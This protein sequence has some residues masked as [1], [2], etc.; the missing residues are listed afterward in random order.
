MPRP[1][2]QIDIV[3]G[4]PPGGAILDSG[5]AFFVGVSER[6]PVGEYVRVSSLRNYEAN[7]GSR[8][9]GSLLY[10]SAG[11]FFAEGGA[12]L[13]VSRVSGPSATRAQIPFGDAAAIA[14]SPGA[15]GNDID[16]AA[17]D[18]GSLSTTGSTAVEV[19]Y[20]G[21]VVERSPGLATVDDLVL[22]AQE[23]SDYVRFTKGAGNALPTVGTTVSLAGGTTDNSITSTGVADAL[24]AFTYELGPGQVAAPGLTTVATHAAVLEHCYGTRRNALLDL[25]DSSDPTVLTAAITALAGYAPWTRFA[26]ALAPWAVYPAST[27]P[28]TVVIPYSGIQAGLIARS[29]AATNNPN[30]PAAGA[31]GISRMALGLTQTYSDD[32]RQALNE[33]GIIIAIVKYG[34]VRTYGYRTASGPNDTNW[35]WYGGSR[36]VNALAHEA[37]AIAENYVL[38]QIDGQ[39][40]LFASLHNALKGLCLEHYTRGALYG[41]TPDEAFRVDTGPTINT[42]QTTAAGEIHA[43]IRVRTSPAAEW[44]QISIVKVPIE[45]S[46]AVAA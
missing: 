17:V 25:P 7:F 8:M 27:P 36:E 12:V 1:G 16:V 22:W 18:A 44:V 26:A 41:A 39:G 5:Q 10:D 13:L 30:V 40:A 21:T 2:T 43:V 38:R 11:A 29:D 4:A 28:A 32:V 20:D 6:G 23:H 37:D 3:D 31:N 19:T 34:D 45:T 14:A 35:L 46:L 9:G 15:W 24:D 42:E 33:A